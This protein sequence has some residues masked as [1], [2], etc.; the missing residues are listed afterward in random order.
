MVSNSRQHVASRSWTL[1]GVRYGLPLALVIAGIVLM[2]IGHG[3]TSST[4]AAT[5][6]V[7]VGVAVISWM[8]NWMFRMSIDSN[9]DREK[10]E[11]AR[12]YFSQ[13]GHWPGEGE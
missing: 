5:G 10:E 11:A 2:V 12:D 7:L 6:L 13:H 1:I 4:A 9:R 8:L 3:R